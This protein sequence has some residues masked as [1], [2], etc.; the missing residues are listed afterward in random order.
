MSGEITWGPNL[1]LSKQRLTLILY[2]ISWPLVPGTCQR[3]HSYSSDASVSDIFF[4]IWSLQ[5][6][7]FRLHKAQCALFL[8]IRI[9]V[10]THRR[11]A[12]QIDKCSVRQTSA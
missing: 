8:A 9:L 5:N 4:E 1:Q 7:Q 12:L 6:I 11:I 10:Y 3:H 2:I